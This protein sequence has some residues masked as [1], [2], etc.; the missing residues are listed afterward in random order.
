EFRLY[1][2]SSFGNFAKFCGG[3]H[4]ERACAEFYI[5]CRTASRIPRRC[6]HH[7]EMSPFVPFRNVTVTVE[8][9]AAGWRGAPA[10]RSA[11]STP[12]VRGFETASGVFTER[13]W[14]AR[15]VDKLSQP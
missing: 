15:L 10:E 1:E 13:A 7:L 9:R 3:H 11:R 2:L 14:P 6:V 8:N 5:L 12:G 4:R